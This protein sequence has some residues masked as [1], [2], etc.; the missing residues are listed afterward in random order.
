MAFETEGILHK[1]FETESK[2][3]SFQAREFVIKTDWDYPQMIK[4]QLT[5]DRCDL[6]N[7]FEEGQKIK[8]HFDLRGREWNEKFFTNLNAWRIE[9]AQAQDGAPAAPSPGEEFTPIESNYGSSSESDQ[10]QAED[11]GDLPF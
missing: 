2:T 7:G 6:I 3:S 1:V 9:A 8:V 10:I 4:F 5:Q 11:F